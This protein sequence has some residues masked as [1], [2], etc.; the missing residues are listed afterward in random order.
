MSLYKDFRLYSTW[1]EATVADGGNLG[2]YSS[3]PDHSEAP[4]R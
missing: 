2:A 1:G 3:P 4:I